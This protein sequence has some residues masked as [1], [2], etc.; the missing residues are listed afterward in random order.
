MGAKSEDD[1]MPKQRHSL[2]CVINRPITK[3]C[4]NSSL[5]TQNW[6]C[7]QLGINDMLGVTQSF[8]KPPGFILVCLADM[9]TYQLFCV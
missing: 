7:K 1:N 4:L 3:Q 8:F 9:L 6:K 5:T 2:D